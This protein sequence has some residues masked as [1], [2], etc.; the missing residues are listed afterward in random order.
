MGVCHRFGFQG[1]I[2]VKLYDL[3]QSSAPTGRFSRPW[4]LYFGASLSLSL[5]PLPGAL[6]PQDGPGG[7]FCVF[8]TPLFSLLP[9]EPAALV[10]V[11]PSLSHAWVG[12][13]LSSVSLA[14]LPLHSVLWTVFEEIEVP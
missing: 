1:D 9:S 6:D 8:S 2:Y 4:N 12:G 13:G 5:H 11:F 7:C 3:A 10:P 14:G